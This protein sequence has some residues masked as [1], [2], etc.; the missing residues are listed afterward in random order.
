MPPSSFSLQRWLSG[1]GL[2]KSG[3]S[4]PP[5]R[6]PRPVVPGCSPWRC[7]ACVR[8]RAVEARH[9]LCGGLLEGRWGSPGAL[10][11]PGARPSAC[12]GHRGALGAQRGLVW[13][14]GCVST[15]RGFC[16]GLP[17]TST[18]EHFQKW[19]GAS[20]RQ[21]AVKLL[22]RGLPGTPRALS[23]TSLGQALGNRR[24]F[25]FNCFLLCLN[26]SKDKYD[27]PLGMCSRNRK[28]LQKRKASYQ[29][30]PCLGSQP[31]ACAGGGS[32]SFSP[33]PARH[34]GCVLGVLSH[35]L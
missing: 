16:A 22:S 26:V 18:Q 3:S 11:A 6:W 19:P 21:A 17:L 14:G 27:S 30:V 24:I 20:Q 32:K 15:A 12:R 31:A 23:S 28:A 2:W 1:C 10:G 35:P 33:T 13:A 29:H 7:G 4:I 25:F 8:P 9:S 34:D 5:T